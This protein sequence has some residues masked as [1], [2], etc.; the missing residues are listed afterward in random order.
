MEG[1]WGHLWICLY[2]P[3]CPFQC[4]EHQDV[5]W[6]SLKP[7]YISFCLGIQKNNKINVSNRRLKLLNILD[8][9][10]PPIVIH[11]CPASIYFMIHWAHFTDK[12]TSLWVL[13]GII[14]YTFF[15]LSFAY[16]FS[17]FYVLC[18]EDTA[19]RLQSKQQHSIPERQFRLY[20]YH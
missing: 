8:F 14:L 9:C 16:N 3:P 17:T 15:T 13:E 6:H 5:L 1:I 2:L 12:F 7:S 11:L 10:S 18:F 19:L 4:C 20:C